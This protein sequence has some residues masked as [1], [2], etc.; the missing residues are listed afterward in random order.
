MQSDH[1]G[2]SNMIFVHIVENYMLT[3]RVPGLC[4]ACPGNDNAYKRS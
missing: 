3:R 1:R 4:V 2:Q